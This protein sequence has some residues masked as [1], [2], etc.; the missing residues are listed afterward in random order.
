MCIED[1]CLDMQQ[2]ENCVFCNIINEEHDATILYETS[3]YTCFLDKYPV[4]EGHALITPKSHIEHLDQA[5]WNSLFQFLQQAHI[6]VKERYDPDATNIGINNGKEA[7]QTI[8]HLH[9][10]IIPRYEGDM[11]DPRGGVRGVIPEKRVYE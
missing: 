10:H 4:T 11:E 8:P 9:W 7:G 2:N 3:N 6:E 1:I 5:N